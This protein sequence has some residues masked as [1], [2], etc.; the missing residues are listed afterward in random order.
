VRLLDADESRGVTAELSEL[1]ADGLRL[2][3]ARLGLPL[4]RVDLTEGL[5]GG[6][7]DEPIGRRQNLVRNLTHTLG[8][9]AIFTHLYRLAARYVAHGADDELVHWAGPAACRHGRVPPDGYGIHRRAGRR[10]QFFRGNRTK[11]RIFSRR[12]RSRQE[13]GGKRFDE[14]VVTAFVRNPI[15]KGSSG[16]TGSSAR[17]GTRRLSTRRPGSAPSGPSAG[18]GTR[19][20]AYATRTTTSTRSRA[21]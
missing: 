9:D 18:G 10:Y 21:S 3:A 17:L 12:D 8:A 14:Y 2:A 16:T 11:A 4:R 1:T 5:A 19:Q 6:G 20:R 7:P 13:I 15:Y